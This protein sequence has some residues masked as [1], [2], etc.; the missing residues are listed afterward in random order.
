MDIERK[1]NASKNV[2]KL[3]GGKEHKM[4]QL[5]KLKTRMEDVE[6]AI[7]NRKEDDIEQAKK[8]EEERLA[9]LQV[10]EANKAMIDKISARLDASGDLEQLHD[11][12]NEEELI[13]AEMET[14]MMKFEAGFGGATNDNDKSHH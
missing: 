8:E 11:V 1:K 10:K 13:K 7:K 4:A 6:D 12:R 2:A 9:A 5:H 3:L 14:E